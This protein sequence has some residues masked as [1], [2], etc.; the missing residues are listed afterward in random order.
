MKAAAIMP[1]E[2]SRDRL[3]F[4]EINSAALAQYPELLFKW[5]PGGRIIGKEFECADRTGAAGKSF[6]VNTV[7]GCF[8]DFA[9]GDKGGDPIALYAYINGLPQVEA[10]EKLAAEVGMQP[11]QQSKKVQGWTPLVPVPDDAPPPPDSHYRLGKYVR[12]W[13]YKKNGRVWGYTARFDKNTQRTNGKQEKEILPLVFCENESGKRAWRWQGFPEPRVLYGL[14]RLEKAPAE[15]PVF[16]T[17]E[18]EKTADAA[19]ILADDAVV[20]VSWQGG[21]GAVAK[22]DWKPL[23]GRRVCILPDAD[24]DGFKS[25]LAVA[26]QLRDLAESI[27][28]FVPDPSLPDGWDVADATD[29]D[30]TRLFTEIQNSKADPEKFSAIAFERYGIGTRPLPKGWTAKALMLAEFP[31]PKWIVFSLIPEGLTLLVARPKKGKSW[32]ALNVGTALTGGYLALGKI[33]VERIEVLALFLEDTPRRIKKRLRMVLDGKPASEG[34]HI[35]PQGT[36]PTMAEGGL[37]R[38]DS[39]LEKHPA[40]KLVIIDTL[41]RFRGGRKAKDSYAED[42]LAVAKVKEVIDRHNAGCI[43]LHHERKAEGSDPIDLVSGTFGITG[44][45]DTIAILHRGKGDADAFL[46]IT[47]RDVEESE[48][49]LH[50]D[51]T[52]G[53]WILLGNADDHRMS[54]ERAEVVAFLSAADGPQGPKD[55]ADGTGKS[56]SATKM[57]LSRMTR[58]GQIEKTAQG[59]YIKNKSVTPV[60]ELPVLPELPCYHEGQTAEKVTGNSLPTDRCYYTNFNDT[61]GLSAE[62][63][64]VTAVTPDAVTALFDVEV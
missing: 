44:A 62:V 21:S 43:V 64:Q 60:T 6:K 37:E 45:A 55:I 16:V 31:E 46:W 49:A 20:S 7:K 58:E 26:E 8:S 24:K 63:T 19:Q 34:F 29:W 52:K 32:L 50:F 25:A 48:H 39:W 9:T 15:K 41:E 14:E 35:F 57:L 1:T 36:W 17:A 12:L 4:S 11:P 40:V 33:E 3:E 59:K 53:H 30:K 22:T 27:S 56:L 47:G 61:N 54:K 10:A 13:P 38:L 23:A 28:I 2:N 18:G 5:L 51:G 42:Y